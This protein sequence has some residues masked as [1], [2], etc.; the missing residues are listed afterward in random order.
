MEELNPPCETNISGTNGGRSWK[1]QVDEKRNTK[2]RK[3]LAR[4][5][6]ADGE[7]DGAQNNDKRTTT[8]TE[9]ARGSSPALP[10]TRGRLVEGQH[11]VGRAAE[12]LGVYQE[13]GFD[14]IDLQK[15]RRSG[16]SALL[17]AGCAGYCSGGSGGDGRGEKD[18]G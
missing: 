7:R 10:T 12:V 17:Q 14:I 11:G 16:P 4:N 5:G 15:T 3:V 2:I 18:Q 1:A 9:F 8:A 13:V 6:G